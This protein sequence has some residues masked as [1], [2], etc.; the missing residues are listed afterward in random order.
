[1]LVSLQNIFACSVDGRKPTVRGRGDTAS[2]SRG[3]R[4]L[5]AAGCEAGVSVGYR[6]PCSAFLC[7]GWVLGI[8]PGCSTR[9]LDPQASLFFF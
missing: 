2:P 1:M 6:F 4:K 3:V 8:G 7:G 5:M 9:E